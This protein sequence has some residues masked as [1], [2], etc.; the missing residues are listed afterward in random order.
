MRSKA[1]RKVREQET[2]EQET[3]EPGLEESEGEEGETYSKVTD[4]RLYNLVEGKMFATT[5]EVK[6]LIQSYST[7]SGFFLHL[8]LGVLGDSTISGFVPGALKAHQ[9]Q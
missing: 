1:N 8:N 4:L 7:T 5:Q 3:E 2:E 9:G 6:K